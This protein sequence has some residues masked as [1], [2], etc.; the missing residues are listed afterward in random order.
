MLLQMIQPPQGK[1][2]GILRIEGDGIGRGGRQRV[3]MAVEHAR[4]DGLAGQVFRLLPLLGGQGGGW[5]HP[6]DATLP[7]AHGIV[8]QDLFMNHIQQLKAIPGFF[9]LFLFHLRGASFRVWM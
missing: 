5:A 4:H 1:L 9:R 7:G 6:D 2:G 3:Y 8:R